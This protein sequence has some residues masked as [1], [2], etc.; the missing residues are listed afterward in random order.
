MSRQ[1]KKGTL[2]ESKAVEYLR[3]TLG[4]LYDIRRT[5]M[6]GSSDEG[7]VHGLRCRDLSMIAE[8]KNCRRYEPKEWL[9]QAEAERANAGADL[10]TVIFHVNGIGLDDM[11]S[12]GVL[13]TL[14]TFC[15]LIGG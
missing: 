5:A 6:H 12:Q 2:M 7:D 11:G 14:G 1:R 13:M 15:K 9:R 4:D 3:E 10:G 8:V